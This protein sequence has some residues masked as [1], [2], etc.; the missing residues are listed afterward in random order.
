MVSVEIFLGRE[1]PDDVLRNGGSCPSCDALRT[2]D[3]SLLPVDTFLRLVRGDIG[4]AAFSPSDSPVSLKLV[5]RGVSTF[6]SVGHSTVRVAP[7]LGESASIMDVR[8]WR[9]VG[10]E[11]CRRA[12]TLEFRLS[13]PE[14]GACEPVSGTFVVVPFAD[15]SIFWSLFMDPDCVRMGSGVEEVFATG[16]LAGRSEIGECVKAMSGLAA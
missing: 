10:F 11:V 3:R 16:S 9:S 7:L 12:R 5:A 1:A 14:A 2:L 15:V 4:L 8:K 13:K 6:S